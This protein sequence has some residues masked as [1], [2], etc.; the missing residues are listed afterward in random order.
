TADGMN[1]LMHRSAR[2]FKRT[3]R[4]MKS[5]K[6]IICNVVDASN[7]TS[8]L[9]VGKTDIEF[10]FDF[11]CSASA[12]PLY[13]TEKLPKNLKKNCLIIF[14]DTQDFYA[15]QEKNNNMLCIANL[16]RKHTVEPEESL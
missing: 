5:Y 2:Y 6:E 10:L 14:S 1:E 15:V 11:A 3:A 16:L 7:C 13:T 9:I 8:V 12:I 4:L